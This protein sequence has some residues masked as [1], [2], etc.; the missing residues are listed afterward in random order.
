MP[1]YKDTTVEVAQRAKD[2]E[3]MKELDKLNI[4]LELESL[5]LNT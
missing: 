4:E 5:R 2:F 1:A 3:R